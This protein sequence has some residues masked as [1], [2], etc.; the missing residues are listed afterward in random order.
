MSAVSLPF[1]DAIRNRS[2]GIAKPWPLR[3][4]ALISPWTTPSYYQ[5][6]GPDTVRGE[7]MKGYSQVSAQGNEVP[8]YGNAIATRKMASM[9]F[10]I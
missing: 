7:K 2:L 1:L 10:K 8:I 3:F 4:A 5:N 9:I 6:E